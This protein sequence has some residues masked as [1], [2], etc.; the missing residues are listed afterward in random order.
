MKIILQ[1]VVTEALNKTDLSPSENTGDKRM[2]N[3]HISLT[4]PSTGSSKNEAKVILN[5]QFF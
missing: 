1:I 2:F 3:G 4:S 5:P